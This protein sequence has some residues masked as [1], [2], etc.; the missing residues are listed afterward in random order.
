MSLLPG[1]VFEVQVYGMPQFDY[2]GRIN[3]ER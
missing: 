3:D 1:D 2:K